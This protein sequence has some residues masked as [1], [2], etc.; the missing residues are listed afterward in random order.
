MKATMNLAEEKMGKTVKSLEREYAGIR[1]GRATPAVLDKV[2]VDYYGVPTPIEQMAAVSV[3]EA[4]SLV[5]QPW[6]ASTVKT[7]EKA[8][9][10]SDIGINPLND[11]RTIRL[12]FPPLTEERRKEIVKDVRK[13]AEES[14]VAIRSIRRDA[15]EKIKAMKKNGE[16]TEDDVKKGETD[17]Q[18]LTDKYVKTI[19]DLSAVK[20]K[21]TLEI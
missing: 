3:V 15:I 17:I 20:E 4:R 21:E 16:I 13:M 10:A 1:A 12:N 2:L 6:D 9:L 8:I 5:I 19:D 11:G 14:K 18:K 7:I